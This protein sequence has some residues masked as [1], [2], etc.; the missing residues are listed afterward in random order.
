MINEENK[1][2]KKTVKK[3]M[4]VLR[5]DTLIE[6]EIIKAG[7]QIE[8]TAEIKKLLKPFGYDFICKKK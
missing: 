5:N 6:G 1:Q 2:E 8:V 7:T 3:E 4:I